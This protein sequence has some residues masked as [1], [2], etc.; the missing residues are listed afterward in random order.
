MK[1]ILSIA[2]AFIFALPSSGQE[3]EDVSP[4]VEEALENLME[5]SDEDTNDE[6]WQ[7]LAL[8]QK[9]PLDLN[10][11][12]EEQLEETQLL[13]ALQ[14]NNLI[15][16]RR[17]LGAF[18]SIYELQAI[19]TWD[20]LTIRRLLSYIRIGTD[21]PFDQLLMKRLKG[22]TNYL[23]LRASQQMEKS[24][25]F[26]KPK[27]TLASHYTGSPQRFFFRYRYQFKNL[28]QYG[29]VGDKDAG[30]QFFNGAQKNGFDFYS[31]HFF[32]KNMGIVKS[33]ALGDFTVNM[34]QGLIQ[35]QG[36]AF[37]KSAELLGIKRQASILRPYS[38]AGEFNFHRGAGITLQ[39]G[40]W[41]STVF[42]SFKNISANMVNDSLGKQDYFTSFQSIGY[43]RTSAEIAD[44][45]ALGEKIFGGNI[46]FKKDRYQIGANAVYYDFS[47]PW[48]K[49]DQ[50]YNLFSVQG[51]TWWNESLDYSVTFRNIHFF[52]E[53]AI[54]KNL[55]TAFVNGALMSLSTNLDISLLHRKI[56][57]AY[58][59]FYSN[60]FTENVMPNN[61]S[62]FFMGVAFRPRTAWDLRAFFDLY[63]FPWLKYLVDAPSSGKEYFLQIGYRPNKIWMIDTRYKASSKWHDLS[64]SFDGTKPLGIIR[65]QSWRTGVFLKL[66]S[67]WE[68]RNR[69]ELIWLNKNRREKEA[70]FLGLMDIFYKPRQT[71]VNGSL[72]LQYFETGGYDSRI[73]AYE[74]D[75][76]YSYSIPVFFDKGVRYYFNL[77]LGLKRLFGIRASSPLRLDGWL[78]WAQTIYSG[79]STIG[80]GLDEIKGSRKSEIKIQWVL[81]W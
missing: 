40:V 59:S 35:W 22:G 53:A 9:H 1:K 17:L 47:K 33:L 29:I 44:R 31:F 5:R 77:H 32:S 11:A 62:G 12:T 79:K 6:N 8:Y 55:R 73:Y 41:Q 56:D 34:G 75:V 28:L 70:G 76:P 45:N 71:S 3:N 80:T 36:F 25:G 57:K 72:R 10:Q 15:S 21:K 54:D 60:A 19:P 69:V 20:L 66:N 74:N 14:I 27:D 16:Y 51:R 37:S 18:L 78:R 46:G 42:A 65:K 7:L 30:E 67:T 39:K 58:Q 81:G 2:M 48:Q 68:I 4:S 43:H 38:S 61:E 50:P 49:R 64:G 13:T 23:L 52:G 24:K 26:E 63:S